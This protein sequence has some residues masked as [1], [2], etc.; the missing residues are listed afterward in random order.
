MK[1]IYINTHHFSPKNSHVEIFFWINAEE[2]LLQMVPVLPK[3]RDRVELSHR[4]ILKHTTTTTAAATARLMSPRVASI[5][6]RH[7]EIGVVAFVVEELPSKGEIAVTTTTICSSS[8]TIITTVMC[9]LCRYC[10]RIIGAVLLF[11]HVD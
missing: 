1:Y 4:P 7:T 3:V 9:R 6:Q 2:Q 10:V 8:G 5:G 11:L